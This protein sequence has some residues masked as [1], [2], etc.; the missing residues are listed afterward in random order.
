EASVMKMRAGTATRKNGMATGRSKLQ[1]LF[2]SAI[3]QV[4]RFS[5]R[6]TNCGSEQCVTVDRKFFVTSLRRCQACQLMYRVPCDDE[7]AN[8]RFYQNKYQQGFTTELPTDEALKQ[9]LATKFSET[10]KCY[11]GY[12]SVLRELG[13]EPGAR[14]FDYGCSWGYGSWQLMDYG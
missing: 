6:C 1:Y 7:V 3:Q 8:A 2:S 10:E 4:S 13:L 9:L 14:I 5:Y 11:R 12:L